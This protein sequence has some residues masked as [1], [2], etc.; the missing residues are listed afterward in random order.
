MN[1]LDILIIALVAVA[2][3][4]AVG[5]VVR[6]KKRGKSACGC[7]CAHCAGKCDRKNPM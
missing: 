3:A 1:T 4:L 7:D 2:V 5:K 6:D